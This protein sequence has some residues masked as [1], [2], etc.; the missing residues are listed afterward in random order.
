MKTAKGNARVDCLNSI[1]Q[2][3]YWIFDE[4][5]PY[6]LDTAC[7]YTTQAFNEAKKL[8]YKRGL[9]YAYA[10][11]ESCEAC[12][13]DTNRA[14]NKK[15][16][17][18]F[19]KAEKYASQAIQIGEELN[20]NIL[21]GEAYNTLQWL[22]RWRGDLE[23][24]KIYV[25]KAISFYEKPVKEQPKGAYKAL[26]FTD[27]TDC[28]GH[29]FQLGDLYIQLSGLQIGFNAAKSSPIEKAIFYYLKA[30]AKSD[31]ARAYLIL[32][33]TVTPSRDIE[34][35][36]GY[37]K[38]SVSL[39]HEDGDE[40]GEYDGYIALCSS[41]FNLGDFENGIEYSKKSVSL[42]EKLA[43]ISS[44]R[45]TKNFKLYQAY[46]WVGRFYSIANDFET[47]FAFMRKA[48]NY[49]P[50]DRWEEHW[51]AAMGEFYRVTG[52]Y[53]SAFY[54]MS[55]IGNRQGG[56]KVI[57]S[58]LYVSM[59]Q[60]D[61]AL[62]LINEVTKIVS[63]R[64]NLAN[65]GRLYTYAAKAYYGK[66]DYANALTNARTALAL[67]KITSRNLELIDNCQLLSDIFNKL[68]NNDSAYIY[69]KKYTILKDSLLNKQL[70]IR[71]NDYKKEAVEAKRIGQ[72]NLLQK[73]N[74]IKQTELQQQ[75]L[76]KEKTE[77]QLTLLDKSNEIKDQ[78]LKEQILLREQ[79]QSQLTLLDK[80]SKLKDQRLK[81]QTFIRNA[82][83]GGL[84]LFILLGVFI[85]RSL[86]FKR[87]N[88]KLAIKKDQA[89]MQQR[90]AELEMQALRAQMNPHF[91]FN[92]LSSIN[93][94]I[95]KNDNKLASDYLTRF[96]RLIRMVLMHS[97]KKL[98]PLEDE[99]EML[100]LYLD[101]ER[102]RFKDAF[103]YSITTTN[104]VDAGAILIPPLLLQPFCENA[105]WH[106]LMNKETK[107]HL[108]IVVSEVLNEG[109]RT[110]HCIIADDGVGR[111]KAAE[112]K[113]KSAAS[114]KSM[115]LKITTERLALL[116][117]EKNISTSYKIEDVVNGNNEVAGTKVQLKI[118]YIET[119]EEYA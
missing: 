43:G 108:N 57:L 94:F 72:I 68:G 92:C 85:F 115:G 53:D 16:G 82:L 5:T 79:K 2:G 118:R 107:G 3:V 103:D 34:T 113:S 88:E 56:S 39:Y 18:H 8:G 106:G 17:S 73:D 112:M 60:Y 51:A 95:F 1:A 74:L 71:M 61:K 7:S 84:L 77:A 54:Y 70:Y 40:S 20:D 63:E 75:I 6:L 12:K 67:T 89:E 26:G 80:E 24:Y 33:N 101:L 9:G 44:T 119:V 27:C 22:E 31:A 42:A 21:I 37:L 13:T 36:I 91:I 102:L 4:D 69:L 23:K 30:G 65:L 59:Q 10:N 48:H 105:V 41:C 47:A 46:Y 62:Q 96:S 93:R 90:V 99:L 98:I 11:M 52:N 83:L 117:Q 32:A 58:S 87:K 100:R 116:N 49:C 114:E 76:L 45:N 104:I 25:Q 28:E 64:N 81:Q 15:P 86:S 111:K 109:R 97:Q 66:T 50:N 38:K 35:G 55:T 78:S 110:L 19:A 29:E 14:E